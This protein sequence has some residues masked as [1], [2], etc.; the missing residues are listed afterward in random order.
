M[1]TTSTFVSDALVETGRVCF[2]LLFLNYGHFL[3]P[4]SSLSISTLYYSVLPIFWGEKKHKCSRSKSS[5]SIWVSF[6]QCHLKASLA[7]SLKFFCFPVISAFT[8]IKHQLCSQLF[9]NNTKLSSPESSSLVNF[10]LVDAPH[11]LFLQTMC[12]VCTVSP[13]AALP[14]RPRPSEI[15][16]APSSSQHPSIHPSIPPSQLFMW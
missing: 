13:T 11:T 12:L 7:L 14:M 4:T 1:N 3:S 5:S 8:H 15:N 6:L 10:V 9:H 2:Q 16:P